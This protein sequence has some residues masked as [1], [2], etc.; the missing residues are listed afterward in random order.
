MFGF[1]EHPIS[2][3]PEGGKRTASLRAPHGETSLS[4]GH[5]PASSVCTQAGQDIARRCVPDY[6]GWVCR[7]FGYAEKPAHPTSKG[8]VRGPGS[9]AV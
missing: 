2:S 4:E 8:S 7:C 3:T 1:A 5:Y 6:S 9:L